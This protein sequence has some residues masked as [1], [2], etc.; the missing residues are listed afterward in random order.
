MI[1]NESNIKQLFYYSRGEL[2]WKTRPSQAIK[3]GDR[4]GFKRRAFPYRQLSYKGKEYLIHRL[5]FL[6]HHGYLPDIIDHK[7]RNKT[8]N[9]IENLRPS[10]QSINVINCDKST[11]KTGIRG[12][13][14]TLNG[15]YKALIT[16]DSKQIYLGVFTN[17]DEAK[18]AYDTAK[19]EMFP[20][21]YT[22]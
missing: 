11:G 9:K 19:E 5:I 3:I 15:K 20:G 22:S 12:V 10:N 8:D 6:Y 21:A 16:K 13:F 7:N 18:F 1:I 4:V 14:P 2:Y 17:I